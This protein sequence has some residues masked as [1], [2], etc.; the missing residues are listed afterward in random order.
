MKYFYTYRY[1]MDCPTCDSCSD[2]AFLSETFDNEFELIE[3][4]K[5]YL[6]GSE[7][8]YIFSIDDYG[9]INKLCE[10]NNSTGGHKVLQ[11]K[12]QLKDHAY[13]FTFDRDSKSY[14]L[15]TTNEGYKRLYQDE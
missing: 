13:D 3:D 10:V 14:K 5:K 8:A 7:F 12:F 15:N 2:E 6:G 4:I 11:V 9:D 1:Y